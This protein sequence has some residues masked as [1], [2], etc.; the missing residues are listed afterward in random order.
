MIG[1]LAMTPLLAAAC[2]P[3][4]PA[5][6]EEPDPVESR[7]RQATGSA[8][9]VFPDNARST[10]SPER[11]CDHVIELMRIELGPNVDELIS[12]Q[13]IADIRSNCI[14]EGNLERSRIGEA[15]FA[16]EAACVLAASSLDQL[17]RCDPD[18]Q[19]SAGSTG[20]TGP[21]RQVCEHMMDMMTRE[22]AK[23]GV[24]APNPDEQQRFLDE[25]SVDLEEERQKLGPE[26]FDAMATCVMLARD[27]DQMLQCDPDQP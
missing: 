24:P 2:R 1:V 9:T 10:T 6:I 8:A 11:L 17:E 20:S 19:A 22:L 4:P 16:Q 14:T 21:T 27:L 26:A 3:Q 18:A 13:E 5:T 23:S 25:C 7:A 15:A 12:A